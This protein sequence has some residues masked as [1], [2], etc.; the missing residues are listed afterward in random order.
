M[1]VLEGTRPSLMYAELPRGPFRQTSERASSPLNREFHRAPLSRPTWRRPTPL[2]TT[3]L[4]F[5]VE[6]APVHRECDRDATRRVGRE[7]VDAIGYAYLGGRHFPR[8]Q[9]IA[10]LSACL[11]RHHL[12]GRGELRGVATGTGGRGRDVLSQ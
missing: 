11:S 9:S 3:G 6:L 10:P 1:A 7:G 8:P 2:R 5:S 12:P 4:R